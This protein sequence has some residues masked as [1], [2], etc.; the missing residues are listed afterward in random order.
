MDGQK[1][2]FPRKTNIFKD[3]CPNALITIRNRDYAY[4]RTVFIKTFC[5]FEPEYQKN[6]V[7]LNE[8]EALY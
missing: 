3:T 1:S 4:L 2:F 7:P 6:R 8:V 5:I